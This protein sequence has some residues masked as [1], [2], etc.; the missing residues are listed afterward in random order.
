MQE[1]TFQAGPIGMSFRGGIIQDVFP[2]SQACEKGVAIGWS[3]LKVN[4]VDQRLNNGK[5]ILE[6][7]SKTAT[8]GE[9]TVIVF[10]THTLREVTFQPGL[11]GLTF[12]RNLVEDV[13][14]NGQAANAGVC[15]GWTIVKINDAFISNNH[16]VISDTIDKTYKSGKPTIMIFQMDGLMRVNEFKSNDIDPWGCAMDPTDHWR[17]WEIIDVIPGE[18]FERQG[19]EV[20]DRI[21]AIDAID[22]NSDN[23]KNMQEKAC[24]WCFM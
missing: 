22:I 3:V 5:H 17:H 13:T 9:P 11:I 16:S 24:K 4:G 12:S 15:A 7:I 23:Y 10:F 20:G 21:L 18:Q 6:S 1:I 2:G 8:I 14:E 19:V